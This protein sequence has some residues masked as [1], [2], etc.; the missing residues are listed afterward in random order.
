[1]SD[2]S[3]CLSAGG[4]TSMVDFQRKFFPGVYA[5]ETFLATAQVTN[6]VKAAYCKYNNQVLQLVVSSL[7]ISALFSGIVASKFAKLYGR[8]VQLSDISAIHA[9]SHGLI[10]IQPRYIIDTALM[11][12]QFV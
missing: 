10:P 1:M 6:P 5:T 3:D 2:V 7:Y 9:Q 8:K 11:H 4:V 12:C